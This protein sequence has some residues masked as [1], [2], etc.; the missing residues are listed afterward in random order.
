MFRL[1]VF[2]FLGLA[3]VGLTVSS[4][5]VMAQQAQ[6]P[7]ERVRGTVVSVRGDTLTVKSRDGKDVRAMLGADT[8]F[9][10]VVRA[11]LSDV[12]PGDFIGTAAKGPK[13]DMVALEVVI[14]P[15]SMRG[16]GEGHYPWDKLPDTTMAGADG[17]TPQVQSSMTN[18]TVTTAS[19]PGTAPMVASSMT[20]GTVTTATGKSGDKELTVSYK[21]QKA[22]VLVPADVPIVRF[23]PAQRSVLTSGAKIFVKATETNGGLHADFVAIGKDGVTPPM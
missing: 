2:R 10:S 4:A 3:L 12:K 21:G 16:A 14:F 7:A 19:A 23:A 8:K 9:A 20:N 18:V 11:D 6:S 15:D 5:G 1:A 13:S 22:Q 17:G